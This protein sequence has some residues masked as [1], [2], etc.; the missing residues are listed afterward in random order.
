MKPI[1]HLRLATVAPVPRSAPLRNSPTLTI[2]PIADDE[3]AR[4]WDAVVLAKAA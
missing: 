1:R 3:E 4:A 2:M